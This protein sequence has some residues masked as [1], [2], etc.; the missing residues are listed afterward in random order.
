MREC[1]LREGEGEGES[2][3]NYRLKTKSAALCSAKAVSASL[4]FSRTLCRPKRSFALPPLRPLRCDPVSDDSDVSTRSFTYHKRKFIPKLGGDP[5][6]ELIK[7]PESDSL[8]RVEAFPLLALP[9]WTVA[10][11]ETLEPRLFVGEEPMRPD[12]PTMVGDH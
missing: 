8:P 11:E 10:S 1:G 12:F 6:S 2:R 5:V 9:G 4:A 3:D 7:V